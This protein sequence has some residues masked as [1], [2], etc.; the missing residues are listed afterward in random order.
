[1][2]E[3]TPSDAL[4]WLD[5]HGDALFA[6]AAKRLRDR[7]ACEDLVQETLL[8]AWTARS[9]FAGQ[10]QLRT[11]LIGILR[12]KLIDRLRKSARE[13]SLEDSHEGDFGP[14]G[15]WNRSP[16]PWASPASQLQEQELIRL[17]EDC[18][19]KLP[20][21]LWAAFMARDVD[22]LSVE[23]A[24]KIL[25]LTP[26]HLGVRLHRARLLLRE[27]VDVGWNK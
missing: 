17:I 8:A 24:C 20:G 9:S 12:H 18:R 26:T 13:T 21:H 22:D 1:M 11:W 7:H 4:G 6:Y 14:A 2:D 25:D 10:S 3:P 27:C 16:G 5:A 19:D 23:E 15:A